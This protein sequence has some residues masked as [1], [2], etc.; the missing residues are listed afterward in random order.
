MRLVTTL[1]LTCSKSRVEA[2]E[3]GVK[4]ANTK[5]TRTT[6]LTSTVIW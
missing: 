6:S 4:Q 5:N 1:T 3:K 2:I